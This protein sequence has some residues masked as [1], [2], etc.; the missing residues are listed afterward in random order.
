MKYF[1]VQPES[2]HN[3]VIIKGHARADKDGAQMVDCSTMPHVRKEFSAVQQQL[4]QQKIHEYF[5][6]F[7]SPFKR[8]PNIR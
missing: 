1:N 6:V 8:R 4:M 5:L 2:S 7:M 3:T